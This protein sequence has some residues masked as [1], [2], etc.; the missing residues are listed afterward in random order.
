MC[1]YIQKV[2]WSLHHASRARRLRFQ[3][4]WHHSQSKIR[5]S[6]NFPRAKQFTLKALETAKNRSFIVQ[7]KD[8]RIIY[9]LFKKN[10]EMHIFKL[11]LLRKVTYDIRKNIEMHTFKFVL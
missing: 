9:F 5:P 2:V 4:D 3:E 8:I 10:N 1:V 11:V 7:K 6:S